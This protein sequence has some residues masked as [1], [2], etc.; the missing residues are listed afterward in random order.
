VL[1][2]YGELITDSCFECATQ[3]VLNSLKNRQNVYGYLYNYTAVQKLQA[4]HGGDNNFVFGPAEYSDLF[5]RHKMTDADKEFA[6][7]FLKYF[8]SFVKTGAYLLVLND[9]LENHA[10]N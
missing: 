6:E 4:N 1:Y 10:K 5:R 2:A 9:R 3:G 8:A 7:N